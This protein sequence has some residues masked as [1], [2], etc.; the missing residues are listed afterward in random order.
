MVSG[1]RSAL[2]IISGPALGDLSK[3]LC[4]GTTG[5]GGHGAGMGRGAR[6]GSRARGASG[7]GRGNSAGRMGMRPLGRG[8]HGRVTSWPFPST[9]GLRKGPGAQLSLGEVEGTQPR[10]VD[11]VLGCGQ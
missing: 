3:N 11:V 7:R 10:L 2:L 5:L 1:N 8:R 6:G 9:Y 4:A